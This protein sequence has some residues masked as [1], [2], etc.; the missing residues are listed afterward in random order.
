[1]IM[2]NCPH[3]LKDMDSTL[4]EYVNENCDQG[5]TNV[6][7][8]DFIRYDQ[9][10]MGFNLNPG[11]EKHI[12]EWWTMYCSRLESNPDGLYMIGQKVGQDFQ[13]QVNFNLLF[14]MGDLNGK[15]FEDDFIRSLVYTIQSTVD[16]N[17]RVPDDGQEKYKFSLACYNDGDLVDST[18]KQYKVLIAL[19]YCYGRVDTWQH[20]FRPEL[21]KNM[22][23]NN[24]MAR[25]KVGTVNTLE[26]IVSNIKCDFTPLYG[27]VEQCGSTYPVFRDLYGALTHEDI[28]RYDDED[29]Y[30]ISSVFPLVFHQFVHDGS[31]DIDILEEAEIVDD[32]VLPLI[33]ST[34]YIGKRVI[35]KA[36]TKTNVTVDPDTIIYDRKHKKHITIATE[37]MS[38]LNP[39]R[40]NSKLTWI[41][42]GKALYNATKGDDKTDNYKLW[43]KYTAQHSQF[44]NEDTCDR[45]WKGFRYNNNNSKK[46]LMY[47]AQQDNPDEYKKWNSARVRKYFEMACESMTHWDIAVCIKKNLPYKYVCVNAE[48]K[49]WYEFVPDQHRWVKMDDRVPL[50]KYISDDLTKLFLGFRKTLSDEALVNTDPAKK[51]SYEMKITNCTKLIKNLKMGGFKASVVSECSIVFHSTKHKGLFDKNPRLTGVKNGVIEIHDDKALFRQGHPDDFIT[52][53]M[54]AC[55]YSKTEDDEDVQ[56][57]KTWFR[58]VYNDPSI[59]DKLPFDEAKKVDSETCKYVWNI[60]SSLLYGKNLDKKFYV[61]EGPGGDNSKSQIAKLMEQALAD[62][63]VKIPT[64]LLTQ[65]RRGSGNASPELAQT[66]GARAVMAD[67]PDEDEALRGNIIK[68][69]TG[70]DSMFARAL[71]DNGGKIEAVYKLFLNCNRTP[72]IPGGGKAVKNRLCNIPHLS[73]YVENA[74]QSE[75]EQWRQS[76]FPRDNMFDEQIPY[77]LDAYLWIIVN[78]YANYAT[79]GLSQP[80]AVTDYTNKYWEENDIYNLFVSE[81]VKFYYDSKTNSYNPNKSMHTSELYADFKSWLQNDYEGVIKVPPKNSFLKEFVHR[82]PSPNIIK[83]NQILG[84]ELLFASNETLC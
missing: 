18:H 56:Y 38:M 76:L 49:I 68:I 4:V 19:P 27:S 14:S 30:T 17:F 60:H 75:I 21:I 42:I 40:F 37:L 50:K 33:M 47:Y 64:E 54:N 26:E 77:L 24:C 5:K 48:K 67:E 25:L 53:Q 84:C 79:K 36:P 20:V 65:S 61:N 22:R 83:K 1:M 74:P 43:V 78:N 28:D 12:E 70:G 73:R 16:K 55:Y 13:L 35:S 15:P 10:G 3:C 63:C 66:E 62:Y 9:Q 11:I 44:Y 7:H 59:F 71:N 8:P 58:Q 39:S 57:V 81:R 6:I 2:S 45:Y 82:C 72:M 80:K 41:A 29:P 52:K 31:I 32:I 23:S 69:L 46:L 34:G 51:D